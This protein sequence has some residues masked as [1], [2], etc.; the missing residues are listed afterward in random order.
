MTATKQKTTVHVDLGER[1]YDIVIA[2]QLLEQIGTMIKPHLARQRVVIVSDENVFAA[3]GQRLLN[4]MTSAEI[5]HDEIIL[6]PGEA[7]KSFDQLQKLLSNLLALDVDRG[8]LI[9]AFGGGVI[10]D[11][12][13][14]AAAILRRGCRFVQIPTS[15]LAQ[16]DSAVGGKTAI[17]VAQGKNLIGAFHQPV[18]VLA[19]IDTLTTLPDREVR[20]GY[21]EIVKYGAIADADFFTWLEENGKS[22]LDGNAAHRIHAVRQSCEMK[23]AIVKKDERE[24]GERALLNLGHTFGHALEAAFG[25]S[26]KLLHGEAVAAGMGMA[27]DFSATNNFCQQDAADRLKAHLKEAGLP[28]DL[29]DIAGH[30][31]LHAEQLFGLMMQDKK[32]EAGAMTLILAHGIGGAFVEKNVDTS[33][34]K[35][36]LK[37]KAGR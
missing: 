20:A 21:A 28:A 14:F 34:L 4:G 18:L 26:D 10:G 27:F 7:T 9:I 6:Q 23:A 8:D 32:I 19:D 3:Q 25:Y 22:L 5:S 29:T 16:V 15:L 13:G 35:Q 12:T 1:A 37:A 2:D 24:A 31:T 36:F 17:N 30:E 33:Y 11:L